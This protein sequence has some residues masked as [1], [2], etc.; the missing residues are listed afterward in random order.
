MNDH[1]NAAGRDLPT[2][3]HD[4]EIT[5]E[6]NV[7]AGG[8]IVS[9]TIYTGDTFIEPDP[10]S[11]AQRVY[12]G[13]ITFM[14][15]YWPE[16]ALALLLAVTGTLIYVR[17]QAIY[18]LGRWSWFTFSLVLTVALVCLGLTLHRTR[19]RRRYALVAALASMAGAGAL[20][21]LYIY[22]IA[23]PRAFDTDEFGIAVATFGWEGDAWRAP[24]VGQEIAGDILRTLRR[25]IDNDD[26]LKAEMGTPVQIGMIDSTR[27]HADADYASPR[28]KRLNADL[29]IWGTVSRTETKNIEVVFNLAQVSDLFKDPDMPSL[30]LLERLL[31]VES[32]EFE[33]EDGKARGL[34]AYTSGIANFGLGLVHYSRQNNADALARFQDA[35]KAFAAEDVQN[36]F[37]NRA[38]LYFYLGKAHQSLRHYEE[39]QEAYALA[40]EEVKDD[41]TLYY[42]QG[43]NFLAQNDRANYE[44]YVKL[45][46]DTAAKKKR[47]TSDG[48][49]RAQISMSLAA[50]YDLEEDYS[51]ALA[52]YA[53]V[54]D[55]AP[56]YFS[57]YIG[58][59]NLLRWLCDTNLD[60][61]DP[62]AE[63][64]GKAL[65]LL[66]RAA[67][68]EFDRPIR[69]MN[70]ALVRGHIAF[71]QGDYP[72][73]KAYYQEALD[74]VDGDLR[75]IPLYALARLY[76]QSGEWEM[77]DAA[78]RERIAL[79]DD[80][81]LAHS[82]YADMLMAWAVALGIDDDHAAALEKYRLAEQHYGIAV[83]E[84]PS[85][86]PY[87]LARQAAA[88][89]GQGKFAVARTLIDS[90]LALDNLDPWE[91]IIRS[92]YGSL[93]VDMGDWTAARVEYEKSLALETIP[94]LNRI[95]N[96]ATFYLKDPTSPVYDRERAIE[97]MHV[98]LDQCQNGY[99]PK[100][101]HMTRQEYRDLRIAWQFTN[102]E[103]RDRLLALGESASCPYL[104]VE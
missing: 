52:E 61:P 6:R 101:R 1:D 38:L 47:M 94:P 100:Q 46:I 70:I 69:K 12:A 5:G 18:L 91:A 73:A 4:T 9:S 67:K 76:T 8:D 7:V 34:E 15:A 74:A 63:S 40:L 35:E 78:Y 24:A 92:Q 37:G 96:V 36:K 20:F 22:P 64:D 98:A 60:E 55:Y 26:Q 99:P 13:F 31:S 45:A 43:Y 87:L 90:A 19:V 28:T 27:A 62:C 14:G 17:F 84:E 83:Q 54:H 3:V 10:P 56:D 79:L 103:L 82:Q 65:Q 59:A 93:L 58:H 32:I 68:L 104:A 33:I 77:A 2:P 89:K 30:Q 71:D 57:A 66:D 11:V 44:Q 85:D 23:W 29:I 39:S 86:K 80:K 25:E 75:A 102:L 50:L 41:P 21:A 88:A 95:F 81:G 53:I 49:E 97:L 72:A 16:V 51:Q 48:N 42:L